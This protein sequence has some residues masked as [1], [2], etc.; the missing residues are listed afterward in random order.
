MKIKIDRLWGQ[1]KKQVTKDFDAMFGATYSVWVINTELDAQLYI[2]DNWKKIY[3]QIASLLKL[4]TKQAYIRTF[5][6]FEFEN[7]WLA[8][9]RMKW[10]L[11]NNEK[12]TTKYRT[13]ETKSKSLQFFGTEIWA[14]DWNHCCNTGETPE[15][16]VN[17]YHQFNSDKLK[18]GIL[19][20]MPKRSVM[21][22]EKIIT[23]IVESIQ[24]MIP[25]A[26][27]STTERYW[28]PSKGFHNRIED[29]NP[30]EL[31]SIV[32]AY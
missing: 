9:G 24:G 11:D 20:A 31:E 10:N 28:T 12:W 6:S 2:W 5:Q 25:D 26:T 13:D 32:Y 8:F 3:P 27:L 16:F 15:L 19:I 7:K 14:P 21:K 30:Q 4:V 17:V 22:N 18:E 1:F 29:M 23:S